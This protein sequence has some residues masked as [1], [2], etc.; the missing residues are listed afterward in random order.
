MSQTIEKSQNATTIT[1]TGTSINQSLHSAL[2]QSPRLAIEDLRI[3]EAEEGL[4]QAKA[5]GRFKLNLEGVAGPTLSETDFRVVDRS[6]TDFRVRRGANLDLSL[7]IYEGG[8][9]NAQKN[10]AEVG[11]NSAK[12]NYEAV[13]SLSLIHI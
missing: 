7:P 10:V 5:Q 12:A 1:S 2:S 6:E 3:R 13:E 4:V 8:R 11:I 9:I